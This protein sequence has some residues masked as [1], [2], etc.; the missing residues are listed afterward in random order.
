MRL[1]ALDGFVLDLPDTPANERAFGRPG[2]AR[3]PGAF[4]QAR[5]LALCEAGTHVLWRVLIKGYCCGENTMT[6]YLLRQL[7]PGMLLL[8]DRNFFKYDHVRQLTAAGAHLLARVKAGQLVLQPIRRLP[9]GSYLSK[10]YRTTYDR[11]HDRNGIVVRVIEYTLNDRGRPGHREKHRLLTTLLDPRLD[12]AKTLVE[13]Y[14][15][16]WEQELAIDEFKTHQ[17]ERP[18]LRSQIPAGVIQ[19]IYGLLLAHYVLRSLMYEAARLS[20]AAEPPITP[21]RLSFIGTL[22]I[23]RCRLPQFPR[24]KAQQRQWWQDLLREIAQ[25]TI[26]PRRN[27]INPRVIKRKMSNWKKKR[28]EH[29]HYPQPTKEFCDSVVMLR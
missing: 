7:L 22:K 27:R 18:V 23:L 10:I 24:A 21:L 5:V 15:V 14:H 1:M 29:R 17:M 4:P 16:R 11:R 20:P 3:A 8:W 19:E 12:E 13:L 6:P 25:E 26:E 28:P 9:D 2:T